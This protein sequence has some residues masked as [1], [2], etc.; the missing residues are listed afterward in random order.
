MTAP[1]FQMQASWRAAVRQAPLNRGRQ[2]PHNTMR[3][4]E[5]HVQCFSWLQSFTE[6]CSLD[7][8]AGRPAIARQQQT[9]NLH[10]R[11]TQ[12]RRIGSV[13]YRV[14]KS[15]GRQTLQ[16]TETPRRIPKPTTSSAPG[17]SM[18]STP[19]VIPADKLH[20]QK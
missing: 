10:Q 16:R 1:T 17:P 11:P 7:G 5:T 3:S 8:H 12:L 9:L 14:G 18:L 15:N 4:H 13:M 20:L 2:S 19:Q 6:V